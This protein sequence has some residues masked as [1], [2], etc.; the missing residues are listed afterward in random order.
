M[1]WAIGSLIHLLL[2]A[3]PRSVVSS[4]GKP[5]EPSLTRP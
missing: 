5:A 4:S 1:G 2:G 3:P